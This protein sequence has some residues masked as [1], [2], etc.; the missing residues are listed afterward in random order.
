MINLTLVP[1][2]LLFIVLS[3]LIVEYYLLIRSVKNIKLRIHVN[4]TRGKSS[5]TEYIAA[6]LRAAGHNSVAKI[7]GVRPT[8]IFSDTNS[9]IIKRRGPARVQEQVKLIRLAS[10]IKTDSLVLEC[11]SIAPELQRIESRLFQPHIYVITNIREDHREQMGKTIEEEIQSICSAIP[12]N[13]IVVTNEKKYLNDITSAATLRSSKV[14][15]SDSL[16]TIY[17]STL[18]SGV[19]ESNVAITLKICEMLGIDSIKS[20]Q[21]ICENASLKSSSVVEL[22]VACKKIKFLN[23]F[24]VNDV[25]SANDFIGYWQKQLGEF[26][27]LIIILNT[28]SDRPLRSIDFSKWLITLKNLTYVILIGS[29]V[30]KTKRSLIQLGMLENKIQTWSNKQIENIGRN[31]EKLTS[32]DA[33]VVG[34][35]NIAGDGFKILDSINQAKRELNIK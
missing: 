27:E 26:K 19:F 31:L 23:G 22:S 32:T 10:K 6:S 15:T 28:R 30:P 14:V 16:S 18:P 17:S 5:V 3:L 21:A 1:F 8:I 13:S 7:T 11:M 20:F 29:H 9:A 2:L 12:K 25:P 35:G 34:I 4:G 33:V 24:P